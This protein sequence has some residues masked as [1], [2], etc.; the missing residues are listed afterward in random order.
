MTLYNGGGVAR[1]APTGTTMEPLAVPAPFGRPFGITAGPGNAVYATSTDAGR[2]ARIRSDG[3]VTM[4]PLPNEPKPWQIVAGP[5]NDDLWYTHDEFQNRIGRFIN[6]PPQPVTG[7]ATTPAPTA[8]IVNGTVDPRG[9]A[10]EARVEYGTTFSFGATTAAKPIESG[11]GPVGVSFELTG[12]TPST[13]Y[14]Y[15]VIASNAE[16]ATV[17]SERTFITPAA[18]A[19]GVIDADGDGAAAAA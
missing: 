1:M 13:K 9:N 16:A 6:G 11:L 12:L 8:A 15:R 3:T 7:D 10:S 14:F 5:A 4:F 19:P 18:P 17:G 2:I